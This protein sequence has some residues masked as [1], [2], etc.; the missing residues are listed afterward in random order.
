MVFGLNSFLDIFSFVQNQSYMILFILMVVEGP[1][2]TTVAA[3]ASSLGYFNIWIIIF[4][5]FLGDFTGDMFLYFFGRLGRRRYLREKRL[6]GISEKTFD[7]IENHFENHFGKTV[8]FSKM[9]L[10][11]VP[12]LILAGVSKAPPRKFAMWS[13]IC[14][15]HNMLI[16]SGIG[17]FLGAAAGPVLET[18]NHVG[19]YIAAVVIL[20]AV[21]YLFGK[22]IS[23]KLVGSQI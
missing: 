10:L 23:K 2:V 1:I 11:A 22:F 7:R 15:I 13:A 21:V 5:A 12:S 18:Y 8:Y 3:F 9:T 14:G 20:A 4:L 17:Y 6:F 19:L 16:F